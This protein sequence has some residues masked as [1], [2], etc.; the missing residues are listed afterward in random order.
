M[1]VGSDLVLIDQVSVQ[2]IE[3]NVALLHVPS[4]RHKE[5]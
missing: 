2:V 5:R 1:I 3:L 4:V